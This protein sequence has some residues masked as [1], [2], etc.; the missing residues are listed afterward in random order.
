MFKSNVVIVTLLSCA[1]GLA[2]AH[3]TLF[4]QAAV[5]EPK[6]AQRGELAQGHQR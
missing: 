5:A 6:E 4:A 3:G 2:C 1:L